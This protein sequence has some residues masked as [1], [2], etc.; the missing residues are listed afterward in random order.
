MPVYPAFD[1]L[2]IRVTGSPIGATELNDEISD[3]NDTDHWLMDIKFKDENTA[4][5]IFVKTDTTSY[6]QTVNQKVN[7]VA[8]SQAAIDSDRTTELGNNYYQTG[9]FVSPNGT[10]F[11]FYSQLVVIPV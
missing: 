2:V 11:V 6:G 3:Q 1:N 7:E 10:L 4:Y 5:L 8:D 9:V